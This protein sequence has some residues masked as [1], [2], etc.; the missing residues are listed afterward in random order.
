[1][2]L[3]GGVDDCSAYMAWRGRSEETACDDFDANAA[4]KAAAVLSTVQATEPTLNAPAEG[5]FARFSG[6]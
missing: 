2:N 3:A 1:M 5:T 4:A 6:R